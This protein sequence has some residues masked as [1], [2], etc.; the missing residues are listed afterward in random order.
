MMPGV[1]FTP[2]SLYLHN[3]HIKAVHPVLID[4]DTWD[5]LDTMVC[6]K[7]LFH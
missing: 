5:I 4:S 6:C 1:V 7:K 2:H 3:L